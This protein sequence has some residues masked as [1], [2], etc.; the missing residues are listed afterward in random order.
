[1]APA[2]T[3]D[4]SA[5]AAG[6]YEGEGCCHVK[7][8]GGVLLEMSQVNL[9]PLQR[10]ADIVG[11][12]RI[13]FYAK[14]RDAQQRPFYKWT[15]A[16]YADAHKVYAMIGPWLSVERRLKFEMALSRCTRGEHRVVCRNGHPSVPGVRCVEC[17]SAWRIANHERE[18]AKQRR[19][20]QRHK[21][22][23]LAPPEENAG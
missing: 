17:H 23:S 18:L 14:T 3:S 20:Y 9:E 22:L 15:A 8:Q 19:Y 5:W 1:M 4:Q 13:T 21:V 6:F 7:K 12:G 11:V 16:S 10:F 2:M